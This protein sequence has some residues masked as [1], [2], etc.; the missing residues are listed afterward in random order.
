MAAK[1]KSAPKKASG[2]SPVVQPEAPEGAGSPETTPVPYR[3]EGPVVIDGF[4]C[5]S[6]ND[7][8]RL[9]LL[10]EKTLHCKSLQRAIAGDI[11]RIKTEATEQVDRITREANGKIQS[12]TQQVAVHGAEQPRLEAELEAYRQA[13]AGAYDLDMSRVSYDDRS[14][15]IFV[16]TGGGHRSPVPVADDE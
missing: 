7:L 4:K 10:L 11:A 6:S 5:L 1:K 8:I 16:D 13:L 3:V 12:L 9:D 15:K 14:G 2:A